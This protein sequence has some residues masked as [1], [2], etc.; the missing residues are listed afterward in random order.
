[1]S[2]LLASFR[3]KSLDEYFHTVDRAYKGSLVLPDN[4]QVDSGTFAIQLEVDTR[5]LRSC[6]LLQTG[7]KEP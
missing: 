4:I 5:G 6:I 3:G 2:R 7:M 1:M